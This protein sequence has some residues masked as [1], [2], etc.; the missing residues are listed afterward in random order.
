MIEFAAR[1]YYNYT[2]TA[3]QTVV[4]KGIE[5]TTFFTTSDLKNTTKYAKL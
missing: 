5:F 3:I 4:C 1:R 2:V